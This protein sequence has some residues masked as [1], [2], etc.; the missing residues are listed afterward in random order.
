MRRVLIVNPRASRVTEARLAAVERAL[1][2]VRVLKTERPG[3]AVELAREAGAATIYA[4]G[5][6]GTFNEVLNG[7]HPDAVLGVLAGGGTNVLARALRSSQSRRISVGRVNGRR[8]AFAAGIGLDAELLRRAGRTRRGRRRGDLGTAWEAA[9]L[10]AGRR[11][12]FEPALDVLGVGEAALALVANG[13]P[14]TYLGRVPIRVARD[15]TFEGGLDL[16][17]P[18]RL[19]PRDYPR[20]L[21]YLAGGRVEGFL[22]GHDLD[23]IEVTCRQ[24]LPLQADGE[25]LGDV[26]EAVFEAERDAVTILVG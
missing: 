14:Y 21:R 20:V 11:G 24:P 6:D 23:R 4:L 25:D 22:R 3:D 8:F 9:R 19:A 18:R 1:A 10:L 26:T 5:G 15:A 2:P 12:R 16:V 17:A 7:A 13:D